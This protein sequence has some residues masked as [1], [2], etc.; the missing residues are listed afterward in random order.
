MSSR[1]KSE[2]K[3]LALL[4]LLQDSGDCVTSEQLTRQ[5][6]HTG[7]EVSGRTVRLYLMELDK[8]GLTTNC[9]KRGR[10]ITARG[11]KELS[12]V[13]AYEKVGFMAAKIDQLTYN[14]DFNLEARL[15]T[16]ITN[17]S[18]LQLSKLPVAV[19]LIKRVFANGFSMGRLL[20]VFAPKTRVGDQTVPEDCLGIGTVCSITLNGVLLA[21][22]IPTN[23]RFGGLLEVQDRQPRR[24]VELIS[25]EGT[26]IDPL[27]IFIRTGMTD[28]TGATQTGHG[29]I[30]AG[31]REVPAD[32]RTRVVEIAKQLEAVGLGGFM[33]IGWPGQ[34]L[35]DVPVSE[36]RAGAI[37]IGGLNPI[38]ILEEHG[39]RV[40]SRAMACLVD[41]RSLFPY[42]ELDE[43]AAAAVEAPRKTRV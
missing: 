30:G 24:F 15:G 22:G 13:Q 6:M 12:A 43:R 8:E 31:F 37:V 11:A 34:P 42:T 32:S 29:R 18:M 23:S 25:Y 39:I 5:L 14:M 2:K 4:K 17:V 19:P 16:V 1:E 38:A 33:T 9:G 21:H 3:R 26:T 20:C 40:P 7:Y 10:K 28:Y 27:E 35:L 36:G 41:Y